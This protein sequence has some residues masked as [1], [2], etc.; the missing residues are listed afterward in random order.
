VIG[1]TDSPANRP[2][3]LPA[4]GQTW[5]L[6]GVVAFAAN[7]RPAIAAVSPLLGSIRHTTGLSAAGAG[8]LTTLPVL[9][10]GLL[11]PAAPRLAHRIGTG[12]LLEWCLLFLIAGIAL[13]SLP[14][15]FALFAGTLVVGMSVALANVLMPGMVKRDFQGRTGVMTGMYTM[16]LSIGSAL[17]A[18]LTVPL[19]RATGLGWRWAIAFW[20]VP[21]ALAL[22]VWFPQRHHGQSGAE[23][24]V[25]FAPLHTGVWRSG[26]A[27]AL[28]LFMGL[29][30]L[31][32]YV[33]LA[34]LPT[35]LHD[36]GMGVTNAGLVL[37]L[38][39]LTGIATA[40]TSPVLAARRDDQR[41]ILVVS[42]L[43]TAGG[44]L[45]F[46]LLPHG[47][48]AIW[49]VVL[50]LGQGAAIGLSLTMMVL[51]SVDHAQAMALSGMAQGG[52][53]LIAAGGPALIGAIYDMTGSWTVPFLVLLFLL[54]PMGLAGYL[55][56]GNRSV[57]RPQPR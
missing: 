6:V 29:Q 37:S 52:G 41:A 27:W 32:F 23:T 9:C 53:Y 42:V 12:M 34:W 8:L 22:V 43:L 10:F 36:N 48:V 50:G 4:I 11:A 15:L 13:R 35:Y 44:L 55:A 30:S 24:G 3:R 51:R 5:L 21:A 49:A 54:L 1:A 31:G 46:L 2:S 33:M 17:G 40:L 26:V 14:S 39:N 56:A 57:A 25:L 20:A 47:P 28:T 18:G 16:M 19:E 38:V 45:G 7:L